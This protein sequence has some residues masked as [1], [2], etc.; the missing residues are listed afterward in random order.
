MKIG[1]KHIVL[2]TALASLAAPVAMA[3]SA[4]NPFLRGRYVAVDQRHQNEFDPEP[5]HAGAFDII[6]SLG[7]SADYNDNIFAQ[8]SNQDDDTI[9]CIRPELEARSTWSSHEL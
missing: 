5:L 4:D 6:S 3:Q 8:S 2:S 9:I 7:V 1:F